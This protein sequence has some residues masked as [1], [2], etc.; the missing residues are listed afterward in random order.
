MTSNLHDVNDEGNIIVDWKASR[1]EQR[2]RNTISTWRKFALDR[3]SA[4]IAGV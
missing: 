3:S 2:V 4:Q 1:A